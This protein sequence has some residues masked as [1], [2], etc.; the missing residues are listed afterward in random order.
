MYV[1]STDR[2]QY[3]H[4][5]FFHAKRTKQSIFFSHDL[6]II[7]WFSYRENFGKHKGSMKLWFLKREYREKL[8]SAEMDD[9]KF[10]NIERKCNS[11]TQNGIAEMDD[12]KFSNIERKCN[13]KTQNG[14]T[15]VLTYHLLLKL[16]ASSV[17]WIK[18][19]RGH[20]L[21]N[22]FFLIEVRIS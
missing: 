17:V 7:R 16:L 19:L 8:N 6:R 15:L 11:K 5:L 12:V 3:L 21:Y 22:P 13:S 4:Y 18:K 9:V 20:L 1:K 14:I 2:H 10:S